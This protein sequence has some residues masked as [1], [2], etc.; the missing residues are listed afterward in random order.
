MSETRL[1]ITAVRT[2]K[3]LPIQIQ[4]QIDI[5]TIQYARNP[6]ELLLI[7]IKALLEEIQQNVDAL[8][9]KS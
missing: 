5:A 8:W 7:E 9:G 6:G 1:Y 4:R 2:E 3:G